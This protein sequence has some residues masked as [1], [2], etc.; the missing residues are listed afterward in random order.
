MLKYTILIFNYSF[1]FVPKTVRNQKCFSSL[2]SLKTVA[3]C[4]KSQDKLDNGKFAYLQITYTYNDGARFIFR[5]GLP[6]SGRGARY[7]ISC[8]LSGPPF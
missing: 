8:K 4:V 7:R 5:V 1:K 6:V 3:V 2:D